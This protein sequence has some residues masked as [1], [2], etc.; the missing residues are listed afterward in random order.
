M[1]TNFRRR[2]PRTHV[3]KHKVRFHHFMKRARQLRWYK[4][5]RSSA[6]RAEERELIHHARWDDLKTK[7]P[8]NIAWEF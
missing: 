4:M 8:R 7:Y 6:R 1:H 2:Q 3:Y 5:E